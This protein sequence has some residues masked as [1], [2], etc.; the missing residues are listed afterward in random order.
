MVG[1]GDGGLNIFNWGEWGA[2][3]DRFPGHPSSVDCMVALNDNFVC[4]GSADGSVR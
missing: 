2:N 3:S 1:D 4:T